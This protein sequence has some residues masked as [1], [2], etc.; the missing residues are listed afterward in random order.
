MELTQ[1][2]AAALS[3]CAE[4]LY[5]IDEETKT[6]R[7]ANAALRAQKG[8]DYEGVPCYRYLC[9]ENAPC[10]S[11]PELKVG[12]PVY[13]WEYYQLGRDGCRLVKNLLVEDGGRLCRV[14]NA[15]LVQ[16][17]INLS[18]DT[19]GE[20]QSL[21][22]LISQNEQRKYALEWSA[23][24]DRMTRLY[25]RARFIR[26]SVDLY[27]DGQQVAL[28][29]F[30]INYLKETNDRLGHQEGD[31][32]I[33]AVSE[34]LELTVNETV[35]VYRMGGDEFLAVMLHAD[36]TAATAYIDAFYSELDA[37]NRRYG[38][39][40][41]VASGCAAGIVSG[42]LDALFEIVDKK[43]YDDKKRKKEKLAFEPDEGGKR[44]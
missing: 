13:V 18:R 9:G 20:V 12:A 24:H 30:D 44:E 27:R 10:H 32:L 14:G 1:A 41:S 37:Y 15:N 17:L 4:A 2:L 26:D 33:L 21:Q 42:G 6:M 35:R 16:P 39:N 25:N 43:M 11:C 23:F 34:I 28:A 5:V 19:A 36:E 7:F 22:E 31:R 38:T 3:D 29:Y 40:F 8:E